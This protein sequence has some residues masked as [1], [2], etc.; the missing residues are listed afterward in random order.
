MTKRSLASL[1]LK[2]LGVYVLTQVAML[3][4]PA[5]GAFSRCGSWQGALFLVLVFV[6]PAIILWLGPIVLL[7]RYSDKVAAKLVRE[8]ETIGV[9]KPWTEEGVL[10]VIITCLGI[11][12]VISASPQVIGLI[13]ALSCSGEGTI[14]LSERAASYLINPGSQ[15]AFEI[16]LGA[17]LALQPNSIVRLIKLLRRPGDAGPEE[18]QEPAK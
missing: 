7:L 18:G 6:L 3:Y 12:M 15:L 1:V 11:S 5:F 2:L 10:R 8:D 14:G 16:L 9:L 4:P 13:V 17:F